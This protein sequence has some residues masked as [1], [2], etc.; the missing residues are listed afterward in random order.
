MSA[1]I[2]PQPAGSGVVVA[3]A[4]LFIKEKKAKKPAKNTDDSIGS[5][6]AKLASL[7]ERYLAEMQAAR[8]RVKKNFLG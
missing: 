7:R 6:I 2:S 3:Q 5:V 1:I 4:P 8:E